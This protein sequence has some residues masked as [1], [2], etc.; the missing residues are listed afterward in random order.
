MLRTMRGKDL[1]FAWRN[2]IQAVQE[3][4]RLRVLKISSELASTHSSPSILRRSGS[5]FTISIFSHGNGRV[6]HS[7]VFLG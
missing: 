1:S 7:D 2:V 6:G 5:Q 3:P 4:V